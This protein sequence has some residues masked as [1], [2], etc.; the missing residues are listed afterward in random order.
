MEWEFRDWSVEEVG[1]LL[2]RLRP[3][4]SDRGSKAPCG[5]RYNRL[6]SGFD[7]LKLTIASYASRF[8]L[9]SL[10]LPFQLGTAF[11]LCFSKR[12]KAILTEIPQPTSVVWRTLAT[13]PD[14]LVKVPLALIRQS[15]DEHKALCV[16]R[17]GAFRLMSD[18]YTIMSHV[19][20]ET[21]AWQSTTGWGPVTLDLRK[22]GMSL[23][24]L[25]RCIDQCET[26]WLW[27]DQIAMPE[28]FEDMDAAQKLQTEWLRID[29]INNLRT[30][31]ARADKVI[32]IDS[33]LLRLN[34]SS[35]VDA[36]FVLSLGYWMTRLWPLT[37]C[38][39]AR[40]VLLKTDDQSFDLDVIIDYLART[41]N[42]DQHRYYPLFERLTPPRPTPPWSEHL[43]AYGDHNDKDSQM[44]NDICRGC[45]TRYT[46]VEID[47]EP[48]VG[49]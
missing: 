38:W 32:I 48:Q 26:E 20:A 12:W 29:I 22:K 31:Y 47:I 44:F 6:T 23:D 46:A 16:N 34:T 8:F 40:K 33:A 45:E 3:L 24:H 41:I 4:G 5:P 7:Y 37:E 19:W 43:I 21:M 9:I 11:Y 36:A 13:I 35:S 28:V 1:L 49:V 2:H 42:N 10:M 17:Q 27:L 39:L 25:E 18:G 14:P 15:N 30:I